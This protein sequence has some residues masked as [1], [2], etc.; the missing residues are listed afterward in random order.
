LKYLLV[1]YFRKAG[2][3]ID[4]QVGFSKRL[5]Q[6]DI[7]T[8][9]IIL[10]YDTRKVEKCVVES[11]VVDKSFDELSNYYKQHYASHIKHLE[12]INRKPTT[13]E[14]KDGQ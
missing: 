4:E 8:C 2:G 10:N 9:N 14:K 7:Q 1:T 13:E 6:S 3:Q 11:R 12:D 5:K